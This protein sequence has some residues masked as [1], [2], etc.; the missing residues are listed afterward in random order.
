MSDPGSGISPAANGR[1]AVASGGLVEDGEKA[2]PFADVWYRCGDGGVGTLGAV[3]DATADVGRGGR[4]QVVSELARQADAELVPGG[5]D[6]GDELV[7]ACQEYVGADG[8]G[9][10]D[11]CAVGVAWEAA[12]TVVGFE[13]CPFG[14]RVDGPVAE[15][16]G[17]RRVRGWWALV[18]R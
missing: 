5:A 6:V 14:W 8:Q 13:M 12:D 1:R 4:L 18:V 10:A 17:C 16:R 2:R 9:F 15:R 11:E 3:A 7:V